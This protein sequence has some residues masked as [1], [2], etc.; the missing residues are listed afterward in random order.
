MKTIRIIISTLLIIWLISLSACDFLDKEPD[1]MLTIDKV[2][3][4][5]VQTEDWLA[6]VYN[7]I[8]D[9]YYPFM[10]IYDNESLDGLSDDMAVPPR[11]RQFGW[12]VIDKQ[13]G[14]WTPSS[15][16]APSYWSS[17]P[18]KIRSAQIFIENVKAIPGQVTQEEADNMKYEA[19]FL[20]AYYYSLLID[21]YGPVPFSP[22][23]YLST[24]AS[25][26][27][28]FG[29]QT[30][31]DEIVDWIDKELVEL[32]TLLPERYP[33]R[34]YGRA[35][36]IMCLAVRARML[37]FAASPLVNGNSK[38]SNF[39][40]SNDVNLF[41]TT[42]DRNKWKRAADASK[43]LIDA[44][45]AAGHKLYYEYNTDGT[46][47]PFMSYMNMMLKTEKQGNL[48]ILFPRPSCQ[49][50]M[51]D[52]FLSPRG[53]RGAGS[54]GTPQSLVD[55]FFMK[56]GLSPILGY[57]NGDRSKP[58]INS[59]SGYVEK[60][61][62]TNK[63]FANTRW[64]ENEGALK[65][66]GLI[67]PVGTYNMYCNREPRFYV[68][69]MWNGQWF[70]A[71]NRETRFYYNDIDGGPTHDAPVN[72]YLVRKKYSPETDLSAGVSAYRPGILY[73]LGEAYLNYAEALNESDPG[74]PDILKYLNLIR[75]R[76]GIPKYGN[77]VGEIPLS[78]DQATV[79][80]AIHK[81]RRVE[82]NNEGIRY[83]DIR[84]WMIGHEALSGNF[85]GMNF[86]GTIKSDDEN[87]E[88]AFFKRTAYQTRIFDD[89]MYWYPV[90]QEEI[91]RN[92][93][94]VQNP[95]W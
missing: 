70:R 43:E 39:V 95:D 16:Q 68:S 57:E 48:E 73:R 20:I 12:Y 37:L 62:S 10:G 71:A 63:V 28:L 49:T 1:D 79:R 77:G 87:D 75:E 82:L 59:E 81:E 17:L 14:S 78:S 76:A 86:Y 45:H 84:R 41:S 67:T 56:N 50:R 64:K 89:K 22:D 60:G 46:I 65:E 13:D 36:S 85:Y 27:V 80:Q 18:K 83:R 9:P 19:R 33:E 58:I 35:T 93:N 2:F 61:F 3:N 5:K 38:Y 53:F 66:R 90:P 34:D 6:G 23:T 11:Y 15:Y 52:H 26:E 74:N 8:P 25:G 92:P 40:N 55:A 44:A 29:P 54:I 94:L 91:D 51:Y 7:K 31:F 42:Y 21:L 30:P 88:R 69:V 32:S 47:D 24:D 4:N 72:G